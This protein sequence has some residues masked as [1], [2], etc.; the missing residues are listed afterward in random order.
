MSTHLYSDDSLQIYLFHLYSVRW[1]NKRTPLS[2]STTMAWTAFNLRT[3]SMFN[4]FGT[5]QKRYQ[6]Q[7]FK[8]INSPHPSILMTTSI[9]HMCVVKHKN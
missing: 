4:G 5:N 9:S 2:K 8:L 3:E 7:V 1:A 6:K